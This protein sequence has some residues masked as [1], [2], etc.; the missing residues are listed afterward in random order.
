MRVDLGHGHQLVGRL[1]HAT[2][3]TRDG[4]RLRT[5]ARERRGPPRSRG[6]S[7]PSR[8]CGRGRAQSLTSPPFASRRCRMRRALP[9]DGARRGSEQRCPRR[10]AGRRPA[11]V[12]SQAAIGH[13]HTVPEASADDS[14]ARPALD[15][16]AHRALWL[17]ILDLD[18]SSGCATPSGGGTR[19]RPYSG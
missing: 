3:A 1:L 7:A 19:W 4:A 18:L 2:E 14:L 11:R 9:A 12:S 8:R 5:P 16:L 6:R 10:P 15:L 17:R 13:A